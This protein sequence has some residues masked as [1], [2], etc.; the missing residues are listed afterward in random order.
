[1]GQQNSNESGG[2]STPEPSISTTSSHASTKSASTTASSFRYSV[3]EKGAIE[4]L[5]ILTQSS[6]RQAP[7]LW[8]R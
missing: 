2:G 8:R 1:M 7:D 6:T 4:S 5:H 3:T